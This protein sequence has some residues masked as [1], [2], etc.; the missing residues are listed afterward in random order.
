VVIDAPPYRGAELRAALWA[1]DLVLAPVAPRRWTLQGMQYLERELHAAAGLTGHVPELRA[2]AT[3]L[4]NTEQ[5][6]LRLELLRKRYRFLKSEIP[7]RE[8]I[9]SAMDGGRVLLPEHRSGLFFEILT[10]EVL[11]WQNTKAASK[12]QKTG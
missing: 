4:R 12:K 1:A 7:R 8:S 6:R 10:G 5:D 3:M 11:R 9:A 2:I